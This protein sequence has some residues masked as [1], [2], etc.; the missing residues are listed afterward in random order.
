[1]GLGPPILALYRQLK[2]PGTFEGIDSV[3]ELGSQGVWCPDRRLLTD[4][5]EAFG[6]PLPPHSELDLYINNTGTGLAPSLHLHECLGF[7]YDCVDIDGNFGSLTLD[8]NFDSV[9]ADRLRCFGLIPTGTTPQSMRSSISIPGS[10][11]R[12]CSQSM[13]SVTT[14]AR[15]GQS[16]NSSSMRS[17]NRCCIGRTIRVVLRSN[18]SK[19]LCAA[20][21][22]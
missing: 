18:L 21:I 3:V 12:G 1:M 14:E 19:P 11:G 9:P 6:R 4:L 17:A 20:E 7:K 13:I 2:A 15:V 8:L 5:F 16:R 10:P 22:C